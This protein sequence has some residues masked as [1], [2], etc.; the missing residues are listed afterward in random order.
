MRPEPK[1][2]KTQPDE[3]QGGPGLLLLTDLHRD[4]ERRHQ[5]E[6]GEFLHD[7][8]NR[9]QLFVRINRKNHRVGND[10]SPGEGG[11]AL[12]PF[13]RKEGLNIQHKKGNRCGRRNGVETQDKIGI[14]VAPAQQP[15]TEQRETE[16]TE[17][18]ARRIMTAEGMEEQERKARQRQRTE[19]DRIDCVGS[20]W[21]CDFPYL[22]LLIIRPSRTP[23]QDQRSPFGTVP[24]NLPL[25]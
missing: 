14:Q 25:R 1:G 21:H 13:P 15:Q 18:P 6:P 5:G 12:K 7:R 11:H 16:S 9:V 24:V 4:Q 10:I 8:N 19:D 23:A 3:K 20:Y 22:C 2:E 17:G